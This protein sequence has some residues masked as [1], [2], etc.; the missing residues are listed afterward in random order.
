MCLLCDWYWWLWGSNEITDD[1]FNKAGGDPCI[2]MKELFE[3]F[4]KLF[5]SE[6]ISHVIDVLLFK[7]LVKSMKSI[8]LY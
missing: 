3:S 4:N 1:P 6:E 8:L 7:I 5:I 2:H